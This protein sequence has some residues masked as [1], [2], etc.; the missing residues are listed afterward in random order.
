MGFSDHCFAFYISDEKQYILINGFDSN[1]NNIYGVYKG[2]GSGCHS[3]LTYIS[4][5]YEQ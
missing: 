1:L 4:G 2:L 3:F 5:L